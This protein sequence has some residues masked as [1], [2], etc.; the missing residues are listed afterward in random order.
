M[1]RL[2]PGKIIQIIDDRWYQCA[3]KEIQE[4][5]QCGLQHKVH[6]KVKD[7]KIFAKWRRVK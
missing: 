3:K 6:L 5:C 2:R 1:S 4:C 7:G